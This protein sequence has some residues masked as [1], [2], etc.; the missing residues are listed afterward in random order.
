MVELDLSW[1]FPVTIHRVV[2][3]DRKQ[4][5]SDN[6]QIKKT[7]SGATANRCPRVRR[8][9]DTCAFSMSA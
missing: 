2:V 9:P 7:S 3:W 4:N 1:A 8:S 5:P 6:N